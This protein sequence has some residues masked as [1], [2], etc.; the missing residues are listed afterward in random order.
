MVNKTIDYYGGKTIDP[1][2]SGTPWYEAGEFS[3]DALFKHLGI[4]KGDAEPWL[5]DFI[6]SQQDIQ[7]ARIREIN[8]ILDQ[9]IINKSNAK[10]NMYKSQDIGTPMFEIEE[11]IGELTSDMSQILDTKVIT[12]NNTVLNN[13]LSLAD[14]YAIAN[15]SF[16]LGNI[17]DPKIVADLEVKVDDAKALIG[18]MFLQ[19]NASQLTGDQVK[20]GE[21]NVIFTDESERARAVELGGL[22]LAG[23]KQYG[24]SFYTDTGA[25]APVEQRTILPMLEVFDELNMLGIGFDYKLDQ[26]KAQYGTDISGLAS[27]PTFKELEV[28]KQA[29]WNQIEGLTGWDEGMFKSY[30]TSFEQFKETFEQQNLLKLQERLNKSVNSSTNIG[31]KTQKQLPA[32]PVGYDYSKNLDIS[33]STIESLYNFDSDGDGG[34]D[35]F[36]LNADGIADT[37]TEAKEFL[38]KTVTNNLGD[39]SNF[40]P[41]KEATTTD[42]TTFEFEQEKDSIRYGVI[43]DKDTGD[44]IRQIPAMWDANMVDSQELLFYSN[45]DKDNSE[46]K[47]KKI[48]KA[49]QSSSS[50]D[51]ILMDYY[52][53]NGELDTDRMIFDLTQVKVGEDFN[54]SSYSVA[55]FNLSQTSGQPTQNIPLSQEYLVGG[56][57]YDGGYKFG[58]Y[59]YN[60][61]GLSIIGKTPYE[62]EIFTNKFLDLTTGVFPVVELGATDEMQLGVRSAL[63]GAMHHKVPAPETYTNVEWSI[64]RALGGGGAVHDNSPWLDDYLESMMKSYNKQVDEDDDVWFPNF[65]KG[66]HWKS[67]MGEWAGMLGFNQDIQILEFFE[68][69]YPE[70]YKKARDVHLREAD[71][72]HK[73]WFNDIM[74]STELDSEQKETKAEILKILTILNGYNYK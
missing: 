29:Y 51:N 26:L 40:K 53:G 42:D 2:A 48:L 28:K 24:D 19:F 71:E 43:R 58:D 31:T 22:I 1:A 41:S 45:Y 32:D 66:A 56:E 21:P 15:Q 68:S 62:N 8:A 6:E 39:G 35:A 59:A 34:M 7:P 14:D 44:I 63:A 37:P 52:T 30:A 74:T 72:N 47:N 10:I 36:D 3:E 25:Q 20:V 55:G 54:L 69:E 50:L 17:D 11:V 64:F 5:M 33:Q 12:A 73:K 4:D 65:H 46:L 13:A 61:E 18:N 57:Q 23:F 60:P 49:Y 16:Q 27:D 67:Q 38:G 9:Q 70:A